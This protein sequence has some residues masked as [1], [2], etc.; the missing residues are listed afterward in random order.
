VDGTIEVGDHVVAVGAGATVKADLVARAVKVSGAVTGNDT[1]REVVDLRETGSIEGDV[2]APRF[3]MA[4][5]AQIRG[6]V[7][8]A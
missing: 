4:E 2:K 7:E 1:A 3:S 5:G 6:K 8:T